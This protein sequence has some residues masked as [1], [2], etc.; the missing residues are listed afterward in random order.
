MKVLKPNAK[1][2]GVQRAAG[3]G[4]YRIVSFPKEFE[5]GIFE[6]IDG[7]F[8][9]ILAISLFI[10]FSIIVLLANTVYSEEDLAN[11]LKE[12][13]V[14]K[15]YE[16]TFD[17]PVEQPQEEETDIIAEGPAEKVAEEA[18]KEDT[19]AKRDEGKREE[20]S[21]TSASERRDRAR[22][23]AA[24]RNA[25]RN[26]MQQQV[27]GT[28]VL[29]ELSAGGSGGSG[30]AVYDVLG[31]SGQSGIGDLDQ[32]LSN[33][34][35]LQSASSSARKS[36]LGERKGSG[37]RSGRAGIDDL[38]T[39][40][41]GQSGST[42]INRDAKFNIAG[43]EGTV[44]G[45]GS[46]ASGR[47]QDAIGRVVT[48]HSDAIESCY[49][50]E[51]NINPNLKGSITVEFTI[52]PNGKIKRVRIVKSTLKSKNVENCISRRIRSWR[53]SKIDPKEGDVR[54]RYKWIFS[55]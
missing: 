36:S 30:D 46:K 18:P 49:K 32:V 41:T 25:S 53:F 21:G 24:R 26:R 37:G 42:S 19:R 12:K 22:R 4:G 34:D 39:S 27:A 13:Y 38:I 28:G 35:G 50:K 45:R 48:K 11:A 14:Q 8:Y 20:A 33:V 17:E 43:V 54:A 10:V 15:V 55:N 29:G 40:G 2:Q 5:K 1:A 7:K 9:L 23:D 31:E 3:G 47:S 16:A 52:D 44:S 51:A 6:G